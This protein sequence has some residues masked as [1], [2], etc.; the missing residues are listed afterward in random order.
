MVTVD[1]M[2]DASD[3]PGPGELEAFREQVRDFLTANCSGWGEDSTRREDEGASR[4]RSFQAAL[5]D[6]G[7][8][9]ITY[10]RELGGAGLSSAHQEAFDAVSKSWHLP[11]LPLAISHG[12]CLPMLNQ[13]GTD[14]Q[15]AEF[16]PD[17]ISG[18]SIWCQMFSEPGAGSD[19]AGLS[20]RA[21][22]DGDQWVLNGQKVW[23]SGAHYSDYGLV[24]ARTRPDVPKH[25]GLSMFIVD[26]TD[27]AVEVRPLRQI[28][29]ESGF[30]EVFFTDLHIPSDWLLGDLNQGWSLAVAMLMFERVSIGAGRGGLGGERVSQKLISLARHLDRDADPHVR[31]ALADLWIRERIKGFIGRRIREAVTAGRVP[32]PE[33]SIAKLNGAL[34]AR[35]IRDVSMKLVGPAGQA[36]GPDSD[37][38]RQWAS[39]CLSAAGIS[40]AGGTDE[41]QRNIIGERVLGLPREPNPFRDTAWEDVPRS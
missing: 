40:I 33:G 8:A 18:R 17:C 10:Q 36:W 5:S 26:M 7:L 30:N 13:F 16:M 4:A 27:P 41:V 28:S 6:A 15:R 37:A 11:N 3:P 34:L 22:R 19:V 20:T 14:A 38:G 31:Q 24:V 21:V 39:F 1:S 9:G 32:G 2:S 25:Q 35:G 29:G 12:M 23:T